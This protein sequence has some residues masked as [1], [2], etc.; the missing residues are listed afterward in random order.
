M[1]VSQN[2]LQ[3]YYKNTIRTKKTIQNMAKSPSIVFSKVYIEDIYTLYY[4]WI[5][6]LHLLDALVYF[7]LKGMSF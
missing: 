4:P 3:R 2:Q 6:G 1:Y 5:N 7:L